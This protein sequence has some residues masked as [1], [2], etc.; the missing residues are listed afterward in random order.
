MRS[1]VISL[2]AAASV[3]PSPDVGGRTLPE[4]PSFLARRALAAA[5]RGDPAIAEVQAAAARCA[6]P[7]A[8]GAASTARSRAAALLPRLTAEFRFDERSY[9][10]TGLQGTGEV[11]Y[12]R[13]APGWLASVRATWELSALVAPP[14]ERVDAKGTLDR[15]RRRDE[16]VRKATALYFERRQ[17]R[18]ALVL[19]PPAAPLER[20]AAELEI[21]RL[22]AELDALTGGAFTGQAA[23]ALR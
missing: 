23:G 20:A 3:Q 8:L 17:L 13:Y 16:A 12:A 1:V 6:D 9:R 4:D 2:L 7:Q 22:A 15:A 14:A 21:E 5:S 19:A 10:V 11:D 18:I